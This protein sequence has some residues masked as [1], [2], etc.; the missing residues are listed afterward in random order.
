MKMNRKA[1]RK[2]MTEFSQELGM[3][4]PA[5]RNGSMG[6]RLLLAAG[7]IAGFYLIRGLFNRM[8]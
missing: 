2:M 5:K 8:K 1:L 3:P 6:K 7:S 4:T